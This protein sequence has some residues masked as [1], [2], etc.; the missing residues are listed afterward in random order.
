MRLQRQRGAAS[1][2]DAVAC[3]DRMIP[4]LVV[5]ACQR[6]GVNKK[7]GDMLRDS[8]KSMVHSVRT[9]HGESENN[10]TDSEEHPV[11]GTGQGSGGSGSY[12]YAIDDIIFDTLESYGS[13]CSLSN[14]QK[15]TKQDR[16]EYGF[17][18]ERWIN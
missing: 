12:W 16:C 3:Y 6:I 1:E 13:T 5:A 18:D 9:A 4:A 14:P 15:T 2:Y 10:F 17:V 7:A 8:L 11:F